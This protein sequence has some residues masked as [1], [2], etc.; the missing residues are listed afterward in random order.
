[1]THPLGDQTVQKGSRGGSGR[2]IA[3]ANVRQ[4]PGGEL[5]R[6]VDLN[7]VEEDLASL[8]GVLALEEPPAGHGG[9]T[10]GLFQV[11]GLFQLMQAPA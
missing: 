1:M 8:P 4:T 10:G 9:L 3:G 5:R 7:L 6:H 11:V 2:L